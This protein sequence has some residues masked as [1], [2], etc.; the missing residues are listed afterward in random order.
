MADQIRGLQFLQRLPYVDPA[1][2]GV[3]GWSYGGFMTLSLMTEPGSGFA[4]GA[5]GAAPSGW[6]M[7]D[8]HYTEHYMGHPDA[9]AAGYEACS[10]LPRLGDLHGRLM[11]IHG[12]ADDNVLFENATQ[13]I[14]RL[15]SLAK[16]FDLML[17][18]GQRHGIVGEAPHQHLWQSL[19]DFFRRELM[20]K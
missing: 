10:I 15:Q 20:P 7:Y 5:A 9:N 18:P 1:R 16:P 4:A 3:T 14:G 8:T 13:I 17:Y 11:L 12:M 19:L 6:D 2:I